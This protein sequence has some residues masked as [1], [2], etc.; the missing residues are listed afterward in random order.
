MYSRVFKVFFLVIVA[1]L[2]LF[3]G[4]TGA[5]A[6]LTDQ[7]LIETAKLIQTLRAEN[8]SLRRQVAL[9]EEGMEQAQKVA[10]QMTL[11]MQMLILAY[12][13]RTEYSD[14]TLGEMERLF[15]Q[16]ISLTKKAEGALQKKEQELWFW[17]IF[18][19][20]AVVWGVTR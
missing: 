8:A 5:S 4:S 13:K 10:A 6:R 3:L 9:L 2:F 18:G 7:E 12:E 16:S 17:R 20:G 19:T 1:S 11:E 14:Q 15:N